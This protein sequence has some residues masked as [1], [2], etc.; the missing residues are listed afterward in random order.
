MWTAEIAY[1]AIFGR[2]NNS[3]EL[4]MKEF[5]RNERL[6][7]RWEN[8]FYGLGGLAPIFLKKLKRKPNK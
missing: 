1:G 5:L 8:G 3:F 6:V 7:I 4:G 2:L